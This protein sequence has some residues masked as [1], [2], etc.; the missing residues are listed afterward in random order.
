MVAWR[1]A[2]AP[3]AHAAAL[4]PP[5]RSQKF[6][7]LGRAHADHLF[8]TAPPEVQ[9]SKWFKL[10]QDTISACHIADVIA[11][12]LAAGEATGA[13]PRSLAGAVA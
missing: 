4:T 9:A 6:A 8:R 11:L 7:Y 10:A 1:L 3:H 13:Q 2:A 12:L 5:P